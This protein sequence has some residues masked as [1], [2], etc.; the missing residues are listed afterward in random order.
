MRKGLEMVIPETEKQVDKPIE[1]RQTDICFY[2]SSSSSELKRPLSLSYPNSGVK[3]ACE[4]IF[5][6]ISLWAS[7]LKCALVLSDDWTMNACATIW[8]CRRSKS[9]LLCSSSLLCKDNN[10]KAKTLSGTL[11]LLIVL[12]TTPLTHLISP[13]FENRVTLDVYSTIHVNCF[14][15]DERIC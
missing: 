9:A 1:E 15:M 14:L 4:E 2:M 10:K 7:V 8:G 13:G 6:I 3:N 5:M 12:S 11:N